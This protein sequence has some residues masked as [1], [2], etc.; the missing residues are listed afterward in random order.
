MRIASSCRSSLNFR[1]IFHA[2]DRNNHRNQLH[3]GG[4]FRRHRTLS[5]RPPCGVSMS[6]VGESKKRTF[7]S[8][9]PWPSK[10]LAGLPVQHTASWKQKTG[11]KHLVSPELVYSIKSTKGCPSKNEQLDLKMTSKNYPK[12]IIETDSRNG[13]TMSNLPKIIET[14]SLNHKFRNLIVEIVKLNQTYRNWESKWSHLTNVKE[15][16]SCDGQRIGRFAD[17][18]IAP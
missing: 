17:P 18:R 3:W 14:D 12:S 10:P 13:Q 1:K 16:D 7:P 4:E 8:W 6:V 2:N 5:S 9:G 11:N 15:T